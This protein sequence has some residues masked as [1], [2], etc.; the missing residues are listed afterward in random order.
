MLHEIMWDSHRGRMYNHVLCSIFAVLE[1][2]RLKKSIIL[3]SVFYT[4]ESKWRHIYRIRVNYCCSFLGFEFFTYLWNP[5]HIWHIYILSSFSIRVMR[6][7]FKGE[8]TYRLLYHKPICLFWLVSFLFHLLSI[9][10]EKLSCKKLNI[11]CIRMCNHSI[12]FK[13]IIFSSSSCASY[14]WY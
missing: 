13:N 9:F 14:F 8:S 6:S 1:P 5:N 7:S 4:A 12:L 10:V 2:C 3:F 11:I